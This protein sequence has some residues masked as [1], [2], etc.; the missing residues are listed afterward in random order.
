MIKRVTSTKNTQGRCW[1]VSL[2]LS[3]VTLLLFSGCSTFNRD[4][5]KAEE[6]PASSDGLSGRWQ[7]SWISNVN[8]HNGKLRCL[9]TKIEED[10]YE[11]RFHAKY[12][13]IFSFSYTVTIDAKREGESFTFTGAA[14]LGTL[15]GVFRYDGHA[16]GTNFFSKYSS[17]HDHG[18]FQMKK[19]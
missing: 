10:T 19:L 14:D 17:K 11:A 8:G 4:W 15:G 5:R 9:M 18:T 13:K 16:E 7:G 12:Q 3:L 6:L 1:V 2:V